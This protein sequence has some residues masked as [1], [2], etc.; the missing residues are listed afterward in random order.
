[1]CSTNKMKLREEKNWGNLGKVK[2]KFD[3]IDAGWSQMEGNKNS[4]EGELLYGL[5]STTNWKNK[6]FN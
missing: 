6:I 2:Y 1:M 4:I 5:N 3:Y